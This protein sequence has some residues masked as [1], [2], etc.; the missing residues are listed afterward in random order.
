LEWNQFLIPG[1]RWQK[2]LEENA[3]AADIEL[4]PE[5]LKVIDE[6]APNGVAAGTRYPEAMMRSLNG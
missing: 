3:R 1:S 6:I 5:Y 2:Y 4:T